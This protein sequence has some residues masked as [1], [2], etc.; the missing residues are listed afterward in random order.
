MCIILPQADA[1]SVM[2]MVD[3]GGLYVYGMLVWILTFKDELSRVRRKRFGEVCLVL[4]VN[5]VKRFFF[6]QGEDGIRDVAVTGVQTCA[7]PIS[8]SALRLAFYFREA[9]KVVLTRGGISRHQAAGCSQLPC[10]RRSIA[11]NE[12]PESPAKT[13]AERRAH[14]DYFYHRTWRYPHVGRRA[15]SNSSQSHSATRTCLTRNTSGARKGPRKASAGCRSSR[16]A[17]ALRIA[18]A[19]RTP[20]ISFRRLRFAQ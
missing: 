9:H 7:L 6:F 2:S 8:Y 19:S 14:A 10:S 1:Y 20:G 16:L 15:L 17:S 4:L 13:V 18:H 5:L 3:S 12:R 11:G